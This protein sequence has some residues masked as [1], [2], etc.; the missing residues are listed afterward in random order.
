VQQSEAAP[1]V[2]RPASFVRLDKWIAESEARGGISIVKEEQVG[3]RTTQ[4]AI[5]AA[6]PPKQNVKEEDLAPAEKLV[7]IRK[8]IDRA[9]ARMEWA[10]ANHEFEKARFYSEEEQKERENL[11]RLCEQFHLEEPPPQV[12]LLCI[13]VI[14]GERFSEVQRRCDVYLGDGVPEVW[15]LDPDLKRAYTVTK[16]EGLRECKGGKLQVAT[17][18]LEMD[19]GTIFI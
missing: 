4:F 18:P 7:E 11:R 6:D 1:A 2:Q 10:I 13:E 15:L 14:S 9:I 5:Y 19:L 17:P 3:N 8:R 12:P 16:A